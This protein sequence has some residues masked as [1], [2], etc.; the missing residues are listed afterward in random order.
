[1]DVQV[2]P[3]FSEG[4][5]GDFVRITV[6]KNDEAQAE[7]SVEGTKSVDFKEHWLVFVYMSINFKG[8]NED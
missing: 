4:W 7:K 6:G 1:M 3:E 8:P 5:R 2:S